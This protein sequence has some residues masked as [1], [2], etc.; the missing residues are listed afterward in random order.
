MSHSL[1][2]WSAT[3]HVS[4]LQTPTITPQSTNSTTT[5]TPSCQFSLVAMPSIITVY[6][7]RS[8]PG[9]IESIHLGTP[10]ITTSYLVRIFPQLE[11]G[12]ST[13]LVVG[14]GEITPESH[15]VIAAFRMCFPTRCGKLLTKPTDHDPSGEVYLEAYGETNTIYISTMSARY[16]AVRSRLRKSSTLDSGI[17]YYALLTQDVEVEVKGV[18]PGRLSF[19]YNADVPIQ[20]SPPPRAPLA[21]MRVADEGFRPPNIQ[22]MHSF[23]NHGSASDLSIH[24]LPETSTPQ[25]QTTQISES[26][27]VFETPSVKSRHVD[28]NSSPR[29]RSGSPS[30][31][32]PIQVSKEGLMVNGVPEHDDFSTTDSEDEGDRDET[33]P[34]MAP[35]DVDDGAAEIQIRV[36]NATSPSTTAPRQTVGR[37]GSPIIKSRAASI[38]KAVTDEDS[39]E[40]HPDSLPSAFNYLTEKKLKTPARTY[41]KK[42]KTSKEPSA[43]KAVRGATE[44]TDDSIG[45]PAGAKKRADKRKRKVQQDEDAATLETEN[46]NAN[47]KL[48]GESLGSDLNPAHA[49][50]TPSSDNPPFSTAPEDSPV[51]AESLKSSKKS[52]AKRAVMKGARV[53]TV[54]ARDPESAPGAKQSTEFNTQYTFTGS[55]NEEATTLVPPLRTPKPR[56]KA[57]TKK[58]PA[59]TTKTPA[60]TK[61]SSRK[62]ST[63]ARST[64]TPDSTGTT[65]A[66]GTPSHI[67]SS[68][69][70]QDFY[71]GTPPRI[72]FTCST[73]LEKKPVKDFVKTH[74]AKFVKD[75]TD[76]TCNFLVVGGPLKR[77]P[78]FYIAVARGINIVEEQWLLDSAATKKGWLDPDHYIPHDLAEREKEWGFK[79]SE[80]LDRVKTGHC[81]VLG[82]KTVYITPNLLAHLKYTGSEGP[83]MDM[84]KVAGAATVIKKSP[85]GDAEENALVLGKE[86]GDTHRD[87]AALEKGGWR[88]FTTAIVGMSMLRGK[89]QDEGDEFQV[90]P[91][92]TATPEPVKNKSGRKSLG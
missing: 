52:T 26:R 84:L 3:R 66:E 55:D 83:M 33:L 38:M 81:D 70:T 90:K 39:N 20:D 79:L 91:G 42:A 40:D 27:R 12:G 67:P 59:T 76:P 13:S 35:M 6:N 10:S 78:K 57:S 73:L 9:S 72:S 80:A 71:E 37:D 1:N 53:S 23:P 63:A 15:D 89:L 75:T 8:T 32:S 49:T 54:E 51:E 43:V 41:A 2:A 28:P 31:N 85:K 22:V 82:G 4:P 36:E 14:E 77:T 50:P 25:D 88:V 44:E 60:S 19:T 69:R 87:L 16:G 68:I 30:C 17:R 24:N 86:D 47:K 58:T 61:A 92:S 34:P 18:F 45:P 62:K 7:E 48:K 11:D 29:V 21:H 64:T 74:H 56:A 5:T 65:H 46:K